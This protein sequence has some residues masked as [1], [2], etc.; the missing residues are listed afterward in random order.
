MTMKRRLSD[1]EIQYAHY[2]DI[3]GLFIPCTE[4]EFMKIK[5]RLQSVRVEY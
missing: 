4:L 3:K 1:F 5:E 2:H